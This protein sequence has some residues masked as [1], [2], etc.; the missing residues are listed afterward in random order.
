M[1]R[2]SRFDNELHLLESIAADAVLTVTKNEMAVVLHLNEC[3]FEVTVGITI[4]IEA[5]ESVEP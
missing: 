1:E 2:G 4:G 3:C 5:V